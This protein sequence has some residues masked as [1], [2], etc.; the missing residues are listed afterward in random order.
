VAILSYLGSALFIVYN[1]TMT[2][3]EG[4]FGASD[5]Y[6]YLAV[7]AL[8]VVSY[9]VLLSV[10]MTYCTIKREERWDWLE[11][12]SIAEENGQDFEG[13]GVGFGS[14]VGVG[15]GSS[16]IGFGSGAGV[17]VGSE[18]AVFGGKRSL[19][20]R[21]LFGGKRSRADDLEGDARA[22]E[23]MGYADDFYGGRVGYV[24]RSGHTVD[25]RKRYI[26]DIEDL[27]EHEFCMG[28]DGEYDEYVKYGSVAK[29]VAVGKPVADDRSVVKGKPAVD[30]RPAVKDRSVAEGRPAVKGKSVADNRSVVKGKPAVDGRPAMKD[31]PVVKKGVV[32]NGTAG[33]SGK[34]LVKDAPEKKGA[35]IGEKERAKEQS[36]I[37]A[38]RA[39]RNAGSDA[40]NQADSSNAREDARSKKRPRER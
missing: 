31:R 21:T 12:R 14:G 20:K 6:T 24:G 30:G 25:L 3:L 22:D 2:I 33:A 16:G 4:S 28:A 15:S 9:F 35:P 8:D 26:P 11:A 5:F 36:Q 23:P 19:F 39:N 17:G 18:D 37:I 7:F 10:L 29:P 40:R 1:H 34:P 32:A 38:D 13:V 27:K